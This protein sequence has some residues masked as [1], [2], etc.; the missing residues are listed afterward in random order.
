MNLAALAPNWLFWLLLASLAAAAIQDI[1]QLRIS[2]VT[3]GAIALFA[4]AAIVLAGP[5]WSVWQNLLVFSAIIAV[6]TAAFGA[7]YVGGGDIKLLAAVGLWAPLKVAM[8]LLLA[9]FL[10]GGAIALAGM[11]FW[12]FRKAS[13]S[14]TKTRQIPYGLAIALGAALVFQTIR[15]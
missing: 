6:G 11:L 10:A 9:I 1:V 3:C 15:N 14:S 13:R 7:G 2:N 12:A 8:P 5:G 4:I